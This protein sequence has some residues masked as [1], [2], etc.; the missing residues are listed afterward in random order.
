M[1]AVAEGRELAPGFDVIEHLSRN[2]ALDVYDV[3]DRGRY[4]R[5]VA[6]TLR[7]DRRADERPRA[8]LLREGELLERFAHPHLVRAYA[9]LLEPEIVVIL[10]TLS[11]ETLDHLVGRRER[12]RLPVA[13]LALL[14]LQVGS[15]VRYLHGE[16]WLHLDLKPSNIIV[17]LGVVK[18]LDLSLVR[19]P[20]PA[21][22]GLGTPGYLA[23]EQALG[24]DLTAAADVWG[25]GA[26]LFEAATGEPPCEDRDVPPSVRT[27]RR[28][29]RPLADGIDACFARHP[30]LRPTVEELLGLLEPFAA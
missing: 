19:P 21:P 5:C 18:L 10:E 3:W 8:R 2:E 23:P 27:L 11:G 1:I 6:K 4:C 30:A 17:D 12:R 13:E 9:T 29:P 16:G 24:D 28:L 22:R 7:P 26:V 15:A 20:G 25:L 14:G